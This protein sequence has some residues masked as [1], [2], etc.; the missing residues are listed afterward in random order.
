MYYR[1]PSSMD[2]ILDSG[3]KDMGSNPVG[4]TSKRLSEKTAFCFYIIRHK[5]LAITTKTPG[6]QD[7]LYQQFCKIMISIISL[8]R[9]KNY[10]R[11]L[12]NRTTTTQQ[13]ENA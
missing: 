7:N 10:F 9:T 1:L 13:D 11:N 8:V 4:V 3:S 2:R 12:L 6:S 5:H